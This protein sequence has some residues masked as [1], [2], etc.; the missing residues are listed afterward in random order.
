MYH[1]I[2]LYYRIALGTNLHI[3]TFLQIAR[4][5][6]KRTKWEISTYEQHQFVFFSCSFRVLVINLAQKDAITR[7]SSAITNTMLEAKTFR[8]VG[9]T[10]L[11]ALSLLITIKI[12]LI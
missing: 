8:V 4:K 1:Q 5:I 7:L 6:A 2:K 9:F 3:A 12:L 11:S 10:H